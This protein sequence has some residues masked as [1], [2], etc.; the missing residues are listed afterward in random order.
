[1]AAILLAAKTE[2]SPKKLVVV[3]EESYKVKLRGMQ[4]GRISQAAASSTSSLIAPLSMTNMNAKF[5]PKSELFVNLRERVLLL[6][7]VSWLSPGCRVPTSL[8]DYPSHVALTPLVV[9]FHV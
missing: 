6:E 9:C 3:I 1:V 4:A 7:R 8:L 2:E 5:D